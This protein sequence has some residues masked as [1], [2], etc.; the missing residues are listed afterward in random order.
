MQPTAA[1]PTTAPKRRQTPLGGLDTLTFF[2]TI[3]AVRSRRE[4]AKFRFRVSNRWIGGT[5]SRGR[6]EASMGAGGGRSHA[7]EMRGA[8][9]AAGD[10]ARLLLLRKGPRT[11]PGPARHGRR[12]DAALRRPLERG[13]PS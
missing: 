1:A 4:L 5:H 9:H 2:A 13:E 12:R 8:G 6:I 10:L 7:R 3:N 11:H